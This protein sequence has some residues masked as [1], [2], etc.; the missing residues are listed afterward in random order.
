MKIQ[1]PV[2]LCATALLGGC[3]SLDLNRSDLTKVAVQAALLY[4][5]LEHPELMPEALAI[6]DVATGDEATR[7]D[8]LTRLANTYLAKLGEDGLSDEDR[9]KAAA[10]AAFADAV[11]QLSEQNP[12]LLPWLAAYLGAL[13]A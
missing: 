9:A 5:T 6:V 10:I 4:I 2:L 13:D 7:H 12:E 3:A 8:A 1:L 11:L